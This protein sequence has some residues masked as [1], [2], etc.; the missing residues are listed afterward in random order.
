MSLKIKK[1]SINNKHDDDNEV[2]MCTLKNTTINQTAACIDRTMSNDCVNKERWDDAII[3]KKC[4]TTH[5]VNNVNLLQM[6]SFGN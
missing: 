2:A 5:I 1:V 4:L 3:G 6:T